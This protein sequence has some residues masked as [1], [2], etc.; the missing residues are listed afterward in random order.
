[1]TL[2]STA[3]STRCFLIQDVYYIFFNIVAHPSSQTLERMQIF[4]LRVM[5]NTKNFMGG[6]RVV[7]VGEEI[8]VL[9]S[10][11]KVNDE[12]F[13]KSL[14]ASDR[15][16]DT[17]LCI[18]PLPLWRSRK[19]NQA[20]AVWSSVRQTKQHPVADVS[21]LLGKCHWLALYCTILDRPGRAR[22]LR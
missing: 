7:Y 11:K 19:G 10:W 20:K 1:M 9:A 21:W 22:D 16:A 6:R 4:L 8:Y 13:E 18:S 17:S 12:T 14:V 15:V 2:S 3:I 5:Q